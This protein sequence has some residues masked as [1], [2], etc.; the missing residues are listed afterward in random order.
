MRWLRRSS[1]R[2]LEAG[3]V[4]DLLRRAIEQ[5]EFARARGDLP[6]GAVLLFTDG[7]AFA[8]GNEV[9]T[10]RDPLAH[11]EMTAIR[12]A[13]SR[14]QQRAPSGSILAC[15]GEPCPMCL[16]GARLYGI[17][18]IACVTT[19]HEA[20]RAGLPTRSLYEFVRGSRRSRGVEIW[21]GDEALHLRA[22]LALDRDPATTSGGH[23]DEQRT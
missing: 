21:G 8:A 14:G 19:M 15:S 5:A 18:S 2:E 22:R 23:D 1:R 13:I 10:R 16:T 3:D 9:R 17:A 20:H 6:F 7:R 12:Q 4:G 11:A